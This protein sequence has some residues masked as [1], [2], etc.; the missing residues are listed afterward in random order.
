MKLSQGLLAFGI[1]LSTSLMGATQ[2]L[3]S[4]PP[5][6]PATASS[7]FSPEQTTQIEQ[8]VHHYLVQHPEVLVE[9]S[10]TLRQQE[11]AKEQARGV[12]GAQKNIDALFGP[13]NALIGGNPKGTTTLVEF[14]DYQCMHCR[15]MATTIEDLTKSHPDLRVVFKDFPIYGPASMAAVSATFAANKQNK[16]Y[17]FHNALLT[18]GEPLTQKTILSIAKK[19]GLNT[20]LLQKDMRSQDAALKSMITDNFKLVQALGLIG[21]PA[22]VLAKTDIV[23]DPKLPIEFFPGAVP[24]EALDNAI[25]KLSQ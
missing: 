19:Q 14:F 17:E 8:I 3:P 16:Y 20:D 18:S 5:S 1:L 13:G 6:N 9:A 24:K 4:Q 22:F 21:T 15:D 2:N 10:E 25:N 12:Q 11:V 7:T 23:N